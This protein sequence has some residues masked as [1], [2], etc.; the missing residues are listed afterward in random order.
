M[1]D[2]TPTDG[3]ILTAVVLYRTISGADAPPPSIE[4]IATPEVTKRYLGEYQRW[5]SRHDAQVRAEALRE[6]AEATR[7]EAVSDPHAGATFIAHAD[8]LDER[9]DRI[10]KGAGL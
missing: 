4:T 10:E 3:E 9:A 1:S 2:Y 5:L 7:G 6:A 8:W